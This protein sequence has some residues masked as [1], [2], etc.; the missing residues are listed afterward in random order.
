MCLAPK[1][2]EALSAFAKNELKLG[3]GSINVSLKEVD[4]TSVGYSN[5]SVP[6][7]QTTIQG[8]K[9]SVSVTSVAAH[10]KREGSR[11]KDSCIAPFWLV[12]VV[13]DQSEANMKL[14]EQLVDY[15]INPMEPVIKVPMMVNLKAVK[16]GDRLTIY[17]KK[18]EKA[19]PV[20]HEN[21][22]P[23]KRARTKASIDA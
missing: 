21:S 15:K 7:G 4:G 10:I 23:L 6:L 5:S 22:Q 1:R 19:N 9:F 2:V 11:E 12:Q 13:E 18:L 14:T 17:V 8:S 20:V 16:A 3:L